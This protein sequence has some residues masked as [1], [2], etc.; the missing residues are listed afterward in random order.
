VFLHPRIL[1]DAV[2]EA[3]VASEK[4]NFIRTEQIQ[5]RENS[6]VLTPEHDMPLLPDVHDFLSSPTLD[7]APNTPPPKDKH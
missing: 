7:P 3:S 4:Y 2:S 1:R 5:M 6:Q